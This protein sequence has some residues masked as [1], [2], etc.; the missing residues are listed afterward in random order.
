MIDKTM[1]VSLATIRVQNSLRNNSKFSTTF[2]LSLYLLLT[3]LPSSQYLRTFFGKL[4]KHR[5]PLTSKMLQ[6]LLVTIKTLELKKQLHTQ[7]KRK[8]FLNEINERMGNTSLNKEFKQGSSDN[9]F[10][11]PI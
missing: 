1:T 9:N 11:I 2:L 3:T 8:H 6:V 5:T 7:V 10:I 4:V